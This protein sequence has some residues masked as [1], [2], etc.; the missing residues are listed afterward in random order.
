[1][2][3]FIWMI[4]ICVIGKTL[5]MLLFGKTE[6]EKAMDIRVSVGGPRVGAWMNAQYDKARDRKP[7]NYY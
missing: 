4:I 1:M 6:A 5:N 7:T 2:N 3:F